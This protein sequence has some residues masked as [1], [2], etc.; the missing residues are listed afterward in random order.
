MEIKKEKNTMRERKNK[1]TLVAGEDRFGLSQKIG[2]LFCAM[3]SAVG[4]G[5]V[6]NYINLYYT[7]NVGISMA[8]VAMILMLTKIT[9]GVTDIVMGMI[10]DRTNTKLGKARPWV[11][12]GGIGLAVSMM[13]LFN[14]PG[15][16]STTQKVIFCAGLYFLVNPIFGTMISVACGALNNL[17]T[18]SSK[19]RGVL[20]VFASYGSLVPVA[21]IGLVVPKM[22]ASMNESQHA[23][24]TV[25]MIFAVMALLSAVLG[26]VMLRETVTEHSKDKFTEKQPVKDSLRDLFQNKYFILLAI[27][28]ILYNLAAAPVV[29]YYAKYVF[30]DLGKATLINIPSLFLIVLLPLAIP[31]I[32]KFGKRACVV[33]GLLSG[34]IGGILMFFANKNVGMFMIGKTIASVGIIPFT[35]ALIPLTGEICDYALYRF[36]KPMDGTIS[37]AATMGGKIGI[38]L[39][40]GLSSMMLGWAGYISTTADVTVAQP[41]SAI[42]MIR[43]LIG[44]YPAVCYGLSALCFWKIDMEK[45][46]ISEIQKELKEQGLR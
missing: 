4:T 8:A 22:L 13:L 42:F 31:L 34:V 17:V 19:N 24:T 2:V 46:N 20:G 12:A 41:D 16:L 38:G 15:S 7:D 9:D 36:K 1:E 45:E 21:M 35:V 25:T 44:I 32:S 39:A 6:P 37:S 14:C 11:L 29:T 18:A 27:G 26:V 3:A 30:E 33:S 28:T 5:Y 43:L 10:I 23:Y 40:A